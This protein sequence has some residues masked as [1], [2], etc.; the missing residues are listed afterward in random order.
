M[1]IS[2]KPKELSMLLKECV[3]NR[4]TVLIKG[5]PGV[6][7]TSIVQQ[8]SDELGYDCYISH[9]SIQSPTVY[10]GLGVYDR[11]NQKAKFLP[12]DFL[13]RLVHADKPTVAFLDDFG[14]ALPSVQ[15]AIQNLL[16]SR[17][18]GDHKVSDN[19]VF[20][21]ATNDRNQGAYVNGVLS[22]IK[23]RCGTIL[24]L[25][26]DAEHWLN[27]AV[28]NGIRPEVTGFIR[29]RPEMLCQ[30]EVSNEIVN[31]PCPRTVENVSKI[32]DMEC[33]DFLKNVAIIGA[34]GE[35]FATEFEGWLRL[36]KNMVSP[37]YIIANPTTA[38]VPEGDALI[39]ITS[40]L[41]YKAN[42]EN[43]GAIMTYGERLSPEYKVNMIEYYIMA[44][45]PKLKETGEYA[46]W[47]VKNQKHLGN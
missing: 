28:K 13:E 35:G 10:M 19:V 30:F 38:E 2:L 6:G 29:L 41:A 5:K 20:V 15:A 4:M 8:V 45:N 21:I 32:L 24:Q 22:T 44:K 37:D 26:T 27:W 18:V 33:N 47:V 1:D 14:Q 11:E 42:K 23:S 34:V 7:K 31:F 17:Q 36:Y 12:Y 39:A 25:D 46:R 9:P 16:S 3:K 43:L 40:A